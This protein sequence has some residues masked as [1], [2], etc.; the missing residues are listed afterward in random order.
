MQF[1]STESSKNLLINLRFF[2]FERQKQ[3][4]LS[5]FCIFW[6]YFFLSGHFWEEC[7]FYLI[8]GLK[9]YISLQYT[10]NFKQ[11]GFFSK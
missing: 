3:P 4:I 2:H 8:E 1:L 6:G 7:L 11:E 5:F 10:M 9:L